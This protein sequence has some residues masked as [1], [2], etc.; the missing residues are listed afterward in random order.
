MKLLVQRP[1]TPRDWEQHDSSDW[2]NLPMSRVQALCVQGVVFEG[3]RWYAVEH[4]GEDCVVWAWDDKQ[5]YRWYFEPLQPDPQL[6][7]AVNTRQHRQSWATP[8]P[9]IHLPTSV[10][11]PGN[12]S[13]QR[14]RERGTFGWRDWGQDGPV[15]DQRALGKYSKSKHT[16]TFYQFSAFQAFDAVAIFRLRRRLRTTAG[17][18]TSVGLGGYVGPGPVTDDLDRV[19]TTANDITIPFTT[20]PTGTYRCQWDVTSVGVVDSFRARFYR[21]NNATDTIVDSNDQDEAAFTGTGLKLSTYTGNWTD[22]TA[23]DRF[24]VGLLVTDADTSVG[25]PLILRMSSDAY[26]DGPWTGPNDGMFWQARDDAMNVP[27]H[28]RR[29]EVVAY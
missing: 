1:G 27:C 12:P 15:P 25:V 19:F 8:N 28:P 5:C 4:R 20:W 13:D 6:G 22:G 21:V 23:T 17:S 10:V 24:S 7:G 29:T 14:F 2:N 26:A 3:H 16:L 11:R 18:G 9:D